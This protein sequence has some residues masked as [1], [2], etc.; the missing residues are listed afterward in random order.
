MTSVGAPTKHSLFGDLI[1]WHEVQKIKKE[2]GL[3]DHSASHIYAKRLKALK[4]NATPGMVRA[5]LDRL[6]RSQKL[7]RRKRQK[8]FE[9]GLDKFIHDLQNNTQYDDEIN[10][11][12]W[13]LNLKRKYLND[14]KEQSIKT[15]REFFL[16]LFKDM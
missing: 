13:L 9:E 14:S 11:A 10:I 16:S 3:S 6:K 4:Y 7:T 1:A 12:P 2:R 15:D 8:L 5:A